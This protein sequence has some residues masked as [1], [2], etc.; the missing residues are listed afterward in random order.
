MVEYCCAVFAEPI[1]G[2]PL[3]FHGSDN[4]AAM[5]LNE[6]RKPLEACFFKEDPNAP[7]G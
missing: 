1:K 2:T 3:W 6:A 4:F 7:S 5:G